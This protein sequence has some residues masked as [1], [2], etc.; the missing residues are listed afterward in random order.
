MSRRRRALL[1]AVVAC[2]AVALTLLVV[3][4]ARERPLGPTGLWLT[5][6][7]LEARFETIAGR[8]VRFVRQGSGP[9]LVLLHGFASSIYTWKDVLPLLAQE[10]D[11]VAL[12]FPG[13][14]QSDCPSD[15]SFDE[16]PAVVLGLLDRLGL[17]RASLVGNSMGGAVAVA[18]AAEQPLR[19]ERL[20]LL[21]AAGFNLDEK[22]RPAAIRL[23]G[24]GPVAA[25]LDRLPLRRLIVG[26]SL[27][28]VFF[29]DALVTRERIDEY[30]EPVLRGGTPQAIRSLLASRSLHPATVEGL[31]AKVVAPALIVWGREDEWIPLRDAG[32]FAAAL[33]GSRVVVLDRCGHMP[34]EERPAEVARHIGAFLAEPRATARQGD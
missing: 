34:Q 4:W 20:V 27:R 31:L 22:D 26:M 12:D 18:V 6:A 21:D 14:G 28:Q 3:G 16:Y 2:L 24:S 17:S 23:V 10:H 29:D 33:P 5:R 13:F 8:R 30:L 11:V 9:P 15:L 1:G 32:R 25:V 7:G 19:V